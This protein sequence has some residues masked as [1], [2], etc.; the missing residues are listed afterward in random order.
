MRAF[1]GRG[2]SGCSS[3]GSSVGAPAATARPALSRTS[4]GFHHAP[5]V[6]ARAAPPV[7]AAEAPATAGGADGGGAPA[8]RCV[9]FS[10]SRPRIYGL[11]RRPV[12]LSLTHHHHHHQTLST[13]PTS[14]RV[15]SGVQPTGDLHLGNYLGAIRPWVQLQADHDA[16][17]CVVD[18]HAIT[19]QPHDPAALR[20]ATRAAAA[21]YLAAGV[22]V[23]PTGAG[24]TIFTQS[25][26]PA[27]AELA[28]LLQCVSPLG[29]L[30]RMTQYKEKAR[31]AK[32]GVE[33]G[34]EE[35]GSEG[36]G[37]D[38]ATSSGSD[39][40]TSSSG[41]GGEVGAGL[42]TYPVLMAADIL[43]YRAGLVPVGADQKQHIE[44][45]RDLAA[46]VNSRF[47]GR[48]WKKMG[49]RGGRILTVPEPLIQTS[50]ARIMSLTDGT[51]KM[52][53]SNPAPGSRINL[54]D[55]P[56]VIASKIKRAKT[57]AE[58]GISAVSASDG[59]TPR[60]EAAN[61][62]T[63]YS[64]VTGLSPEAAAAEVGG[65]SWGD[66]KP[67]LAEAVVEH[68]RPLQA[69]YARFAGDP[70]G[71]DAVLGAGAA[72]AGE[73]AEG[74]LADVRQAMGFVPRPPPPPA[75]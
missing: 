27:H 44:L 75:V 1:V 29:W 11:P 24:A 37:E 43:L 12:S 71:L 32:G 41:G 48:A 60:P 51:S 70:A 9:F 6:S 39:A 67:R 74:T 38:G 64:A 73:V 14:L 46:R 17:F 34:S 45:A 50:G 40:T 2:G 35:D 13:L 63:I 10:F 16:F 55:P 18:L 66:F 4:R 56:D 20:D 59:V 7:A 62:L 5:S 33:G 8:R 58:A 47:G 52:S 22:D 53:K 49:G 72:R 61:L 57:D 3:S 54:L 28:W 19:V 36:S 26:V 69:G 68:L 30:H 23:S 25:H 15:L 65:L 21:L 31:A 42:L